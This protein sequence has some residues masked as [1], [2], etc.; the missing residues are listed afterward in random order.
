MQHQ[1]WHALSRRSLIYSVPG[2]KKLARYRTGTRAKI[3]SSGGVTAG[4][5]V[6]WGCDVTGCVT[7]RAKERQGRS[8][9]LY[10]VQLYRGGEK[11]PQGSG[12]KA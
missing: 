4:E 7:P 2:R 1:Q 8:A 3:Y 11:G 12:T 10:P 9:V 5:N 6:C